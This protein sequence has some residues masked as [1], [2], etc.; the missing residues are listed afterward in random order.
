MFFRNASAHRLIGCQGTSARCCLEASHPRAGRGQCSAPQVRIP[1]VSTAQ[2]CAR[3]RQAVYLALV[4]G[5]H[6]LFHSDRRFVFGHGA[7]V[8]RM[9]RNTVMPASRFVELLTTLRWW[10]RAV[11][12][13]MLRQALSPG[14]HLAAYGM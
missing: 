5:S 10:C 9:S 14:N 2:A 7:A 6:P 3:C 1:H 12:L 13:G 4:S 11:I 8:K